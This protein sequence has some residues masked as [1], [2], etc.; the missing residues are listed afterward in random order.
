MK[1]TGFVLFLL[2][3]AC[4]SAPVTELPEVGLDGVACAGPVPAT[5][6]GLTGIMN[7]RLTSAALA[8]SDKGGI[9]NARVFSAAEPV[10]VY[11]VYDSAKGNSTFGRW[12]SLS[13]PQGPR[14]QYRAAYA[15]C[16]EWSGLD[17]LISCQL[18]PGAEL[19]LGTTQSVQCNET[20]YP[21]SIDLQ[22]YIP[23]DWQTKTAYVDNC[24]EEGAWPEQ[25]PS[26]PVVV[27][28]QESADNPARKE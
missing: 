26:V 5:L 17:R 20:H 10:R 14:E 11:R 13:R 1:H 27:N 2:L 9:C 18:K 24:V 7:D 12:W 22:V 4:S 21:K 16:P 3:S 8:A 28:S 23:N 19:V 15:I 6:Q 25:E